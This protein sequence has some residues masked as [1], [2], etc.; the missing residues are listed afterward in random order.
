VGFAFFASS[1]GVGELGAGLLV[2]TLLLAIVGVPV[3]TGLGSCSHLT[4]VTRPYPLLFLAAMRNMMAGF[5]V[6][7]MWALVSCLC[8]TTQCDEGLQYTLANAIV[9]GWA[10]GCGFNPKYTEYS[11]MGSEVVP[12]TSGHPLL[13]C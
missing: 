3:V 9:P 12:M 11:V 6:V 7:S 10:V 13:S 4:W 1:R 5:E 2:P 8:D